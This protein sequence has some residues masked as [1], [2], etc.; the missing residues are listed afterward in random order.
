VTTSGSPYVIDYRGR[1]GF[2]VAPS[3]LWASIERGERF[4]SWWSWLGDFRLDGERLEVG[5]VMHGVVSP[6][7]PYRMRVRV[8]VERCVP[9]RSVDAAVHG[10]IEGDA[11]LVMEPAGGGT[12]V[13]VQW[14][15][16]M[17]QRA[18]RMAAR[19][20]HPLLRWGH[21]RVVEATVDGYRRHVEERSRRLEP[22]E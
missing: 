2:D 15:I 18:M 12:A 10:D 20:A 6:P 22:G 14:T 17:M 19:V 5:A 21:D 3:Q 7:V 4:E 16:E 13:E 1:F 8:V 11:R 9:C